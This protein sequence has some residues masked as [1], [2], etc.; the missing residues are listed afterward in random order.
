VTGPIN[1]GNPEEFS[2]LE[3]ASLV[4][5]LTGSHSRIVHRP[6][7]QDVPWQKANDLL[8]WVPQAALREGLMKTIV[9]FEDLLKDEASHRHCSSGSRSVSELFRRGATKRMRHRKGSALTPNWVA[10][11]RQPKTVPGETTLAP[12]PM[13]M[14]LEA[15]P[16]RSIPS[17]APRLASVWNIKFGEI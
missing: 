4:I 3:L 16:S 9:Y 13:A 15:P 14:E 7:P 12:S 2:I 11:G 5:E 10:T 8:R 1:V 17:L 6:R